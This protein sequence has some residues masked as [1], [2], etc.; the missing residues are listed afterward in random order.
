MKKSLLSAALF[1]FAC[2][3][4]FAQ[5]EEEHSAEYNWGER[6]ALWVVLG[7]VIVIVLIIVVVR[8]RKK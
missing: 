3:S 2:I 7:V 4:I 8:R 5:D 6:N 1:L